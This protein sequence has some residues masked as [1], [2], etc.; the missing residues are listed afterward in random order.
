[1]SKLGIVVHNLRKA[2][3]AVTW[4]L[5]LVVACL[6]CFF[7]YQFSS[8]LDTEPDQKESDID[9]DIGGSWASAYRDARGSRRVA[10]DL[11]FKTGIIP[12]QDM[13]RVDINPIFIEECVEIAE[14]MLQERS[15]MEWVDS[16]RQAQRSFEERRTAYYKDHDMMAPYQFSDGS[17]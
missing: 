12:N 1:M 3:G 15:E 17:W 7:V 16:W 5:L 10:L 2:D 6:T 9:Y 4:L 14:S 11:L 8:S 13:C